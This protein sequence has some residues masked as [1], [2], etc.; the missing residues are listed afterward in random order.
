MDQ[1]LQVSCLS[2]Q[3]SDDTFLLKDRLRGLLNPYVQI[4]IHDFTAKHITVGVEVFLSANSFK[5]AKRLKVLVGINSKLVLVMDDHEKVGD[6]FNGVLVFWVLS[7]KVVPSRSNSK[8][9]EPERRNYT[10]KFHRKQRDDNR[11][12]LG[13]CIEEGKRNYDA[14]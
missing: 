1:Q 10:L 11:H 2:G 4:S 8:F 14:E 7:T 5:N 12:L 3:S 9:P 6:K 13:A